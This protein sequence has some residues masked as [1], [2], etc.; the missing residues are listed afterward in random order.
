MPLTPKE[1]YLM[2]LRGEI[3]EYMPSYFEPAFEMI[4]EEM[5]A[6]VFAPD[7]PVKTVYGVEYVGSKDV[8]N[9]ALPAPG[10]FIL[11]DIREWRDVIKNPDT[12]GRDW[13]GYYKKQTDRFDR[14]NK[15]VTCHGGDYFLTLVSFMGFTEALIAMYE[16]PEEVYALF[17]YISEFYCEVMRQQVRWAKPEVYTIMDDD[18]AKL[19]PFFS[20]DMYRRL[21]KPFH[22]KHADIALENGILL[23]RHDCGRSEQFIDDWLEIGIRSWNPAQTTNDL[24][25]IKKKYTGRLALNGCWDNTG[26]LGSPHVE[27]DVLKDALAEYVDTFAPGGGFVFSA[28]IDGPPDDPLVSHKMEIIKSFFYDYARDYYKTH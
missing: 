6:P 19:A 26:P 17:D 24:K 28:R 22:K 21:I 27:D 16:E 8:S 2:M 10:K 15:A 20:L 5:L 13:E 14:A 4:T 23:D 18:S 11:K 9:G 3:P 25:T 1:N 7:G 12:S